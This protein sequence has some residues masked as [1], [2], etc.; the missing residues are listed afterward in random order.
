MLFLNCQSDESEINKK[1]NTKKDQIMKHKNDVI[2]N[3]RLK[4]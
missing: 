3:A 4:W 2:F 1:H